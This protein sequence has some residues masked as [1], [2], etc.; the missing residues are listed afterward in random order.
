MKKQIL[1]CLASFAISFPIYAEQPVTKAE[2]DKSFRSFAQVVEILRSRHVDPLQKQDFFRLAI[3]GIVSRF[4]S[5]TSYMP[6]ENYV[7][8]Q[9]DMDGRYAG[10]GMGASRPKRGLPDGVFVT[11]VAADGPAKKAGIREGDIIVG[12]NNA[13]N[14]RRLLFCVLY[15]KPSCYESPRL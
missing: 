8:F 5:H 6:P 12:A 3:E 11:E 4:D 2:E 7:K 9:E 1:L 13:K 10:I 15:S 14:S